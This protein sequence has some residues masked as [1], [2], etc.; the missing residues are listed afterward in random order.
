MGSLKSVFLRHLPANKIQWIVNHL[1]MRSVNQFFHHHVIL[2]GL[3]LINVDQFHEFYEI[4]IGETIIPRVDNTKVLGLYVDDKLKWSAHTNYVSDKIAKVCGMIYNIRNKLTT[5]A[6]RIIYMSLI[7]SHLIYCVPIWGNTWMCH[8][9]PVVLAQ[10][11]AIRTISNVA[12]YDHT[13]ELFVSQKLLKFQYIVTYFSSLLIFKFLNNNYAPLVF[14]RAN[15]PYNLRNENN[16]I[17][18]NSRSELFLKSVYY[19]AP[20]VWYNLDMQLKSL[21]NINAFKYRVKESLLSLQ[22]QQQ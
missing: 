13:H 6:M 8:L 9:R 12:R 10:K 20:S 11:R 1:E 3:M 18:P 21:N 14:S 17:I 5:K 2:V 22:I 19:K 7:Y 15:N 16:V 4:K